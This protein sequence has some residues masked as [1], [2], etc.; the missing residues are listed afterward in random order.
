MTGGAAQQIEAAQM[1]YSQPESSGFSA[2]AA[3]AFAAT[4]LATLA[5][6]D[7]QSSKTNRKIAP[8]LSRGRTHRSAH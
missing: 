7:A 6:A 1:A 5:S 4:E 2:N 3:T 8:D